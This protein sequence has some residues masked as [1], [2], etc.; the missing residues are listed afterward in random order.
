MRG[1]W[2]AMLQ[3]ALTGNEA[4]SALVTSAAVLL[5]FGSA[6]LLENAAH[7][8]VD[9]PMLAVVLALTLFRTQRGTDLKGRGIGLVVLPAIAVLANEVGRLM[10]RHPDVGDASFAAAVSLAIWLRRFGDR[11]AKA[12]T[13][14]ALPFVTILVAPVPLPPGHGA[15]WWSA[16][17]AVIAFCWVWAAQWTA[18][19]VG[20]VAFPPRRG[21]ARARNATANANQTAAKKDSAMWPVASTRMAIQMGVALGLAFV[22]GR[23]GFSP[24]WTWTLL[25]AFIV[26]SGNRGRADVLHK[27]LLRIGGAAFGTVVATLVAGAFGPRDDRSIV[28]IFVVLAVATWLRSFSYAYW[29]GCITA[30][31]ALLQGYFGEVQIS[32]LLTRLEEILVGAAIAVAVAWFVLPVRST[33]VVRRR[34][35]DPLAT[36]TDL[37]VAM[38]REPSQL[39]DL[40]ARFEGDAEQLKRVAPPIRAH[41]L[42]VHRLT[43]RRFAGRRLIGRRLTAH[44]LT[45][46][47]EAAHLADAIDAVLQCADPVRV[48]AGSGPE[49]SPAMM[50][51]VLKD[52]GTVRLVAA[53]TG[54]VVEARRALGRR[55]GTG[56]QRPQMPEAD[57]SADDVTAVRA[58]VHT[59]LIEIDAAMETVMRVFPP[60]PVPQEFERHSPEP[61]APEP[62]GPVQQGPVQRESDQHGPG[63]PTGEPAPTASAV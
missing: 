24:R 42:T 27:S 61:D 44:R 11:A 14:M 8:N 34:I 31:L 17:I 4:R 47:G 38:R 53:V 20:F 54:N 37:L 21:H 1:R 63:S 2:Y 12:G 48:L 45:G 23:Y 51:A 41:R 57:Q 33:D 40:A 58:A 16:L 35:A 19:R 28:L 26:T 32:L 59:A 39:T 22:I 49:Q 7:L 43:G 10:L 15:T 36:L 29:A 52:A 60:V 9:T 62:E 30:V 46:R 18:E 50:R 55:P 6:L 13:L 5:S 25:T 56:H 3:K